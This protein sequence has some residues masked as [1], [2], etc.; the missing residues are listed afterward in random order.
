VHFLSF[1]KA[2]HNTE[3]ELGAS[4]HPSYKGHKKLA[5]VLIPYIST[6]TGWE[7]NDNIE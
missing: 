1:T 4:W 6:L 2:V 7:L 3:D 5:H